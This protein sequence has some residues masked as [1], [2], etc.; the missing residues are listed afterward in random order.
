MLINAVPL[1]GVLYY[2]WS[3]INVLVLY[4][5]EN[6]LIG[7]CTLI[8]LVVHRA[9]TRKR[10]YWRKANWLGITSNDKPVV[11]SLIGSY[12]YGMIGFT[13]AHGIFV[14]GIVIL[15]HQNYPELAIWQ[16]SWPQ[17]LRGALSMAAF[18]GI[19]LAVD[20][21]HIRG[22][23]FAAL[24]DYAKGGMGRIFVLHV[25]IIFG[26]FAMTIYHSPMGI[27]YAL[28]VTKTF[29]D[30][31]GVLARD[32]PRVIGG[33]AKPSS[34]PIGT[35][36]HSTKDKGAAAPL[37]THPGLQNDQARNDAVEDEEIMPDVG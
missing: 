23:S 37:R 18:L 25:A 21:I 11:K 2:E 17:V 8:R 19:D 16:L 10:G 24:R 5:F 26:M 30:L 9:C 15:V 14:A 13:A 28:I 6:L 20:L 34:S 27:L 4:W 12:L 22:A 7:F 32:S 33:A 31:A 29:V 36:A 3:A 35:A 1:V